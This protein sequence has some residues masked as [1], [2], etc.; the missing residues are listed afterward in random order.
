MEFRCT[1]VEIK[2]ELIWVNEM[3]DLKYLGNEEHN[4]SN[5]VLI[6]TPDIKKDLPSYA[7]ANYSYEEAMEI[8]HKRYRVQ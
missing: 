6:W 4:K 1:G 3:F 7:L 5:I 8:S 2:E